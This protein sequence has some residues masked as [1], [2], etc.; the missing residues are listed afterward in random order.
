MGFLQITSFHRQWMMT[1]WLPLL[2]G[3]TGIGSSFAWVICPECDPPVQEASRFC[4]QCGS[5][6]FADGETGGPRVGLIYVAMKDKDRALIWAGPDTLC[7]ILSPAGIL[8]ENPNEGVRVAWAE[9]DYYLPEM[10]ILKLRDGTLYDE[11]HLKVGQNNPWCARPPRLPARLLTRPWV[12]DEWVFTPK[13]E[14]IPLSHVQVLSTNWPAL[15]EGKREWARRR[16]GS[17]P[18]RPFQS[19]EDRKSLSRIPEVVKREDPVYPQIPDRHLKGRVMI[20]ILIDPEGTPLTAVSI[21][22]TA[23]SESLQMAA[24]EAAYAWR[25]KSA[26]SGRR[27]LYAWIPVPFDFNE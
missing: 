5:S 12:T 16:I 22:P 19:D 27:G 20:D 24:I 10:G 18:L 7:P 26:R 4:E 21:Y 11:E 1:L 14:T 23:E 15:Q 6:F 17:R 25:F 3:V 8:A 13:G 2:M 9:I